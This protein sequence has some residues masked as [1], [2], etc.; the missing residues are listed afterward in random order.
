MKGALP[1]TVVWRDRR[2]TKDTPTGPYRTLKSATRKIKWSYMIR[3]SHV[4]EL[5]VWS[6]TRNRRCSWTYAT[7]SS[8]SQGWVDHCPCFCAAICRHEFLCVCGCLKAFL[9][10]LS[11]RRFCLNSLVLGLVTSLPHKSRLH[12]S[13]RP[14]GVGAPE[15]TKIA[16]FSAAAAATF[17][18]PR[19][20]ARFFGAPS[21]AI[22]SAKKIASEPR[23]L[24]RRK[25]VKMV[26]A[27]EFPAIPSSAVEIASE[28]RCAILVHSGVHMS[29]RASPCVSCWVQ[30]RP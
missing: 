19:K 20:I 8:M 10:S 22:S 29:S 13:L 3:N 27:A 18:T 17:T 28:R 7:T 2:E 6:F 26:L 12:C 5:V 4:Q 11:V 24:L 15:C 30:L 9:L 23:C 14:W 25:W 1:F 21:C 16:R